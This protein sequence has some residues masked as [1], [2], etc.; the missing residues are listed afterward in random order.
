MCKVGFRMGKSWLELK[1]LTVEQGNKEGV[2]RYLDSK[3]KMQETVSLLLNGELAYIRK[4]WK[5]PGYLIPS[6]HQSLLRR[7]ALS[8]SVSWG[9]QEL[10]DRRIKLWDA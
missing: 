10:A 3:I 1:Q 7:S 2:Y 9:K 4:T 8:L 6:L 5:R